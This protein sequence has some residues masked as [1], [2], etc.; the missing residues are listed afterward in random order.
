MQDINSSRLLKV[1]RLVKAYAFNRFNIYPQI[2]LQGKWLKEAG[3]KPGSTIEVQAS[4]GQLTIKQKE[5][6]ND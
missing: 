6:S 3:F 2:R 5:V 1:Y 4:K